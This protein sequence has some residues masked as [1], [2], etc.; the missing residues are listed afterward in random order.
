MKNNHTILTKKY[1]RDYFLADTNY[2]H[3][4]STIEMYKRYRAKSKLK[5]RVDVVTYNTILRA[6]A[7]KIEDYLFDGRTV[8]L[9]SRLGYLYIT[10][11][12]GQKGRPVD[13]VASKRFGKIVEYDNIHSEGYSYK[14]VHDN[15]SDA[16][17][18]SKLY[19][20]EAEFTQPVKRKLAKAIK[21]EKK[22]FLMIHD[23]DFL[24]NRQSLKHSIENDIKKQEYE[25]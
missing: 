21:E 14:L 1:G 16:M 9:P 20:Y 3:Y 4:I 22:D 23:M 5:R 19:F 17:F 15:I 7:K 8:R 13:W 25:V 12:Y 6:L 24:A 10:K 2:N 11:I 18:N